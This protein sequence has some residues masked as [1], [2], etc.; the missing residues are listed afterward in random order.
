MYRSERAYKDYLK[1]R[2]YFQAKRIYL[3]N[4]EIYQ[5]LN[6]Y[7]VNC[8]NKDKD[9]I[10]DYLF[11]LEDWFHQ[12]DVE[13]IDIG[14]EEEFVFSRLEFSYGFPQEVKNIFI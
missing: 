13:S 11:H 5:L 3:A 14:L 1:N 12:F 4:K 8:D 2:R 7:Y 9:L 10:V 6:Q